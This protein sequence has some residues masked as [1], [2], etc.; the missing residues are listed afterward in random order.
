MPVPE[1]EEWDKATK[2]AHERE[3]LGL[4]V[5]DHPLFGVEH[6]L[7]TAPTARSA[8]LLADE[9]RPDGTKVTIAGLITAV[10]R[11][12]TKRGDTWAIVTIEDLEG[13]IE[14]MFFPRRTS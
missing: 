9:D 5:S 8:T 1:I 4:Y 6:V 11:K 7:A 14:V 10:Q 13:S 3:M 2:L 12:M